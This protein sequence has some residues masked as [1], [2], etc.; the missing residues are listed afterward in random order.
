[1]LPE[2]LEVEPEPVA[3]EP[4]DSLDS[5]TDVLN[6]AVASAKKSPLPSE[7][8]GAPKVETAA[9]VTSADQKKAVARA[10]KAYREGKELNDEQL[11]ALTGT[12]LLESEFGYNANGKEH[13]KKIDEVFRNAS[14]GHYN[15]QKITTVEQEREHAIRQ[16]REQEGK[17]TSMEADRKQWSKALTAATRGNFEPLK[18][19]V[20]EFQKAMELDDTPAAIPEGYV[21]E[22]SI[23]AQEDGKRAF[24]HWVIPAAQ[25]LAEQFNF[26]EAHVQEAALA[27]IN[28]EPTEFMTEAKLQNILAVELPYYVEQVRLAN[29]LP[30]PVADP[31]DVKLAALEAKLAKLTEDAVDENND[32]VQ[33]IHRKRKAAPP[34]GAPLTPGGAGNT[35]SPDWEGTKDARKWLRDQK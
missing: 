32:R 6:K 33:A 27:L 13:R 26:P 5:R 10:W 22:A 4:D 25:K 14:L 1:M 3:A 15:Q 30:E 24:D 11:G 34:S 8:A 18:Q 9:P 7:D 17:V 19:I 20:D 2:E 29:P 23:K 12:Q 31:R 21:S 16:W 35:E 28:R